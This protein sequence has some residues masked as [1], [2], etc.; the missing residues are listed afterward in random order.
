MLKAYLVLLLVFCASVSYADI[1]KFTDE[2]G[3]IVFT[4]T[5]P[6]HLRA[7]RIPIGEAGAANKARYVAVAR[8]SPADFDAMIE[9]K[10]SK[11][12]LDPRLVKAVIKAESNYDHRAVSRKGAIGLMQVMPST[13]LDMGV[14]NLFNP[15]ENIEAGAK[16]LR[17]M[18][19]KFGGDLKLALAAYNA[20]PRPVERSRGVPAIPETKSYVKKVLT[21][22]D[23][24]PYGGKDPVASPAP[25]KP[26]PVFYKIVLDD[27]TVLFTNSYRGKET[28]RF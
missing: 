12:D 21:L 10:A 11:H 6:A 23:G 3:A 1:Y 25:K 19:N 22:Y 13:G 24:R 18:L 15:E 5:P 8:R 9:E 20:G 26:E 16:Y 17:L 2:S 14:F 27:G 4:D 28:V 7:E